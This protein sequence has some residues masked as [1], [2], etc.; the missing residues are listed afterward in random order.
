MVRLQEFATDSNHGFHASV[1]PCFAVLAN[2]TPNS[3]T[4]RHPLLHL[5]TRSP[6]ARSSQKSP[7]LTRSKPRYGVKTGYNTAFLVPKNSTLPW[8]FPI[9]RGKDLRAGQYTIHEHMIFPHDPKSGEVLSELPPA[10][11]DH[12]SSY[13]P[14]LEK[15][16]DLRPNMPWWTLFRVREDMLGW[17][18]AW[19][20]VATSLQAVVL[21]Q[22]ID[23]GPINLNSTYA[24]SCADR[25]E[26]ERR[27]A[28]L[29]RAETTQMLLPYAQRARNG[30][31]RFDAR[32][33][34]MLSCPPPP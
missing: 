22:V 30:Y 15:R 8:T 7:F 6:H 19:R 10:L 34:G 27:C 17:R 11:L 3:E 26:A 28:W 23:G 31:Y 9:V 12:L 24:I 4:T 14:Q 33:V 29:N 5:H 32:L 1:Y 16:S 18:V 21:P 20:D 13:R 2:K 25:E